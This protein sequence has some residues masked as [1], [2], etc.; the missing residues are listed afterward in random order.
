LSPSGKLLTSF[1]TRPFVTF[2][3][4]V[5][6]PECGVPGRAAVHERK[7]ERK[8]KYIFSTSKWGCQQQQRE[9]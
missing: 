9:T 1:I 5:P 2:V 7:K 6:G 8:K 3:G 4:G